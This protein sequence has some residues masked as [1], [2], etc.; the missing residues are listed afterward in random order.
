[1]LEGIKMLYE[2]VPGS[3]FKFYNKAWRV[4]S[5]VNTYFLLYDYIVCENVE[6]KEKREFSSETVLLKGYNY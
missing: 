5:E 3:I 2:L 1:M 6:N 4:T